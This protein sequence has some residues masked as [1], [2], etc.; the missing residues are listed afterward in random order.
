[1]KQEQVTTAVIFSLRLLASTYKLKP[2]FENT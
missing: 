1:M 2:A